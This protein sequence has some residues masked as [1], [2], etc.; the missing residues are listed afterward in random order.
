MSLCT[1]SRYDAVM[2]EQPYIGRFA[3]SPTGPLH[4]GSLIAALASY[5]DAR[6]AGGRWH[7][8]ID[9][10]DSGRSR[11]AFAAAIPRTLEA[12]GLE[13][14][15][16]I[17]YQDPRRASYQL[18]LESLIRNGRAY[19]CACTRQQ[20]AAT[21]SRG[22][23]GI[24]YPGTCRNGLA[25]GQSPRSW[26]FAVTEDTVEFNDRHAGIQCIRACESIGDFVIRRGDGLH[27]YHLAMVL[28]DAELGVTDVVRGADLLSA[29]APQ[30]LLQGA[31]GL[32]T[33]RY[34]HLPIAVD[35]QGRKLSKTNHAPAIETTDPSRVLTQ[36]L[37]FLGHPPPAEIETA[38]PEVLLNWAINAWNPAQIS[39][40]VNM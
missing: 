33:P 25:A 12:L 35:E 1:G 38:P 39:T 27:A 10:V 4:F 7:L 5:L 32:P 14:D 36:A 13:W 24:I 28:D 9:D 2:H 18:A 19:P 22:P 16:A 17:Q 11:A 21:A 37:R 40:A 15:G 23:A 34:L 20:I 29:T 30:I 8:R 26:R 31:L 6:Q 3:P